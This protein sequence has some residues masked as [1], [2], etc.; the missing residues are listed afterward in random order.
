MIDRISHAGTFVLY[1]LTIAVGI[2][3]L[4]VAL[5]MT[6]LGMTLPVHKLV[7]TV[8]SLHENRQPQTDSQ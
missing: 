7:T 4:P 6:R 1:Q 8:E 2:M 5:A 3:L